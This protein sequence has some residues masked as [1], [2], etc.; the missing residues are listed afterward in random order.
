MFLFTIID[1]VHSIFRKFG[2][3]LLNDDESDYEDV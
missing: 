1:S 3:P 2:W